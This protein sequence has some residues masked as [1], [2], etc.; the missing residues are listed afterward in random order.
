MALSNW[1]TLSVNLKG[2]HNGG[3]Y[4]SPLGVKVR[5][6]KNWIYVSDPVA[7][8]EN[9]GYVKDTIMEIHKGTIKYKDVHIE[10]I[11]GPQNGIYAVVHSGYQHN[12]TLQGMVGCGVYGYEEE[13]WVGVESSSKDFLQN[14][15][16][17]KT[18]KSEKEYID[19]IKNS[20]GMNIDEN[21]EQ[22]KKI[23]KD[24]M[25]DTVFAKTIANIN[26]SESKRFNQGDAYFVGSKNASTEVGKQNDTILSNIIK[27]I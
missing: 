24:A 2:E 8:K 15:I 1:D 18:W 6:Y 11:R 27:N 16:S 4:T 10:A 12:N 7:W 20:I 17:E 3:S 21:N 23:I 19:Y 22:T 5:F 14:W 13:E 25:E 26:L 9:C